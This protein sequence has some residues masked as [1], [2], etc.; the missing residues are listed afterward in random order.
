M[1]GIGHNQLP[2]LVD[3]AVEAAREAEACDSLVEGNRRKAVEW[4]IEFGRRCIAAK[5]AAGH[6]GWTK[7]REAIEAR[8]G[9]A[10]RWMQTLMFL[11]NPQSTADLTPDRILEL[12]GI[13]DAY[14]YA[15]RQEEAEKAR[16]AAE[17][18]REQADG[19]TAQQAE[20]EALL[21]EEKAEVAG[22]PAADRDEVKAR[23]R[24]ERKEREAAERRQR[25]PPDDGSIWHGAIADYQQRVEAGSL[26]CVFTDPPYPEEFLPVWSELADFAVHA[27]KPGGVLLAMSGQTH[28]LE[29]LDRLRV[30]GLD[31]RWLAAYV[32]EKP[33]EAIHSRK[34]KTGWKPLLAFTRSGAGPDRR[35]NDAFQAVPRSDV[36]KADHEW[37]QT[38][39]DMEAIAREWTEP[40]WKV[41]DP[42]C[43]AGALLVGA[44]NAGCFV[45]GC[46]LDLDHVLTTRGKLA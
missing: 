2:L 26:H 9:W 42:F 32:F 18:A 36:D 1:S 28:L 3:Q 43:G 45:T 23:K 7:A 34:V 20:R 14:A 27:L 40:G 21:A 41:C 10:E 38:A 24:T 31:Y 37:G 44:R 6:G 22:A 33:R 30:D 12:G 25:P 29:V 46:D 35:S 19:E 17:A 8:T 11:A 16:A 5:A 15:K 13:N 4:R 39:A